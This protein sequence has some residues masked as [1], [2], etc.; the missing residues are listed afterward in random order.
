V[1]LTPVV[2]NSTPVDAS[3]VFATLSGTNPEKSIRYN[4][5]PQ[6]VT[7]TFNNGQIRGGR[8]NNDNGIRGLIDSGPS[9]YAFVNGTDITESQ[10]SATYQPG[11]NQ[12]FQLGQ[13][14]TGWLLGHIQ[15]VLVYN[16]P[17][18]IPQYRFV[19]GYLAWK[20]GFQNSLPASHPYRNYPPYALPPFPTPLRIP[21]V[22]T[23]S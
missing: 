14:N 18:S 13:W 16:T 11:V 23:R 12:S 15:E 8:T 1:N 2:S 20:W 10:L 4:F 17:L 22:I 3:V 7:Y 21:R 19:E 9:M 5:P 6:F